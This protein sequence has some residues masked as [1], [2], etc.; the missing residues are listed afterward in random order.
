MSVGRR[1]RDG[2]PRI[3]QSERARAVVYRRVFYPSVSTARSAPRLLAVAVALACAGIASAA[4]ASGD[5]TGPS[6]IAWNL[7][8]AQIRASCA[9]EI[10]RARAGV[11][12]IGAS[13]GPH[14][15]SN[16]VLAFENVNADLTDRLVAQTFLS[17]IGP[18]AAIRKVSLACSN[19]VAAFSAEETADPAVYRALLEARRSGTA[20]TVADRALERYWLK[21]FREA[22]AA[23]ATP[24]RRDFVRT[25]QRL[26]VAQS[27]FQAN[28]ASDKTTIDVRAGDATGLS[29]EFVSTLGRDGTSLVVPVNDSSYAQVLDNAA[30]PDVRRRFYRAYAN[31]QVPQNLRVLDGEIALR[32]RLAHLLGFPT[33]AAYRLSGRVDPSVAHIRGFLEALDAH[34]L[35]GARRDVARLSDRYARDRGAPRAPL[36][37]WD[38]GYELERI[39]TSTYAVDQEKIKRYFPAP[40]VVSAIMGIYE[41]LLGV[42]FTPVVP[43]N[44]Y[45]ASV[46]EF[47][48]HDTASGRFVGSFLLDLAPRDGKP[49]GAYNAGILP[50]RRLANGRMR[51][52]ISAMQVSDWP[53]PAGGKP[54]LLTH[55]DVT[56]FF[57]EFGHLMA[58]E[59]TTTPYESLSQFD[60]DFVE[61]PS[62]MLENFVWTPSVLER[63]SANVDT[64]APLPAATIAKMIRARCLTDR[65]CNAYAATRQI[66]LSVVDLDYHTAGPRVDTTAIWA[67]DQRRLVP[68]PL[69]PGLH[70]QAQFEHLSGGYDAGYY[71]Y[72]W[73]LVYAQDLF[74]AFQKGGIENPVV[75]MRYRRTILE[76]AA[77]YGANEEVRAFLGRPMSPSAFYRGFDA[78]R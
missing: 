27:T 45:V 1:A 10:A 46:T 52:P 23:L 24:A 48:I 36:A 76:P 55:D 7:T 38:V 29:P 73:S 43:A 17:Q 60:Q 8:G 9:R 70:P 40:H 63:I 42:R 58:A 44:A 61:A 66:Q 20:R 59:L 69:P 16:T 4:G 3:G 71:T 67:R 77:T 11:A 53:A 62:Q 72:L 75:G 12:E 78:D 13:A 41:H 54:A 6:T 49:G 57:H 34:V 25:S 21:A 64:G 14:T 65:L 56:T 32:D 15:F 50:V 39:R 47:A 35:P 30:N 74:T 31:R 18:D 33:W 68:L 26:A 19:D 37:L 22:G 28:L 5:A 2:D 51:P